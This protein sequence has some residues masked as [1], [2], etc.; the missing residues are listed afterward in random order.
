MMMN[1]IWIASALCLVMI[2]V[3]VTLSLLQ[4]QQ[5]VEAKGRIG[6]FVNIGGFSCFEEKACVNGWAN[7]TRMAQIDWNQGAIGHSLNGGDLNCWITY[8]EAECHGY[9]H[10][11]IY[12]WTQLWNKDHHSYYPTNEDKELER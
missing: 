8:S 7:G 12:K 9:I 5:Q 3:G 4:Q 1:K 2:I 10:G 6:G 11:Y